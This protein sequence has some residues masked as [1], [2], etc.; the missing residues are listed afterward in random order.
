MAFTEIFKMVGRFKKIAV[1]MQK[2][3]TWISQNFAEERNNFWLFLPALIGF[4]AAFYFTFEEKFLAHFVVCVVL[5]SAAVIFYF[6]NRNSMRSLIFIACALFLLGSFYAHFYQKI[7][8][9]YTKISGKIYVEGVGKIVAV[10]KFIN[11]ANGVSGVNLVISEPKLYKAK[12]VEKKKKAKVKKKKKKV[13]KKTKS[14]NPK[15][16]KLKK[17]K[18]INPKTVEKNFVNLVGFQ[19]IDREFLDFSKN[20]QSVE[21]LRIKGKDTFPNPPPKI[22]LNIIKNSK[23]LKVN[24]VIAFRAMLQPL[25]AREFPEDFD[26]NLDA[27]FKKIGAYG[28]ILSE[29]KIVKDAEISRLDDWFLFLREKIRGKI[30]NVISGDEAAIASAFLI[31]D[32]SQISKATMDKIRNSGLAHLL[33]ISGFHLSLAGAICFIATRFILSRSEYLTLRFDL[34]K[35]AAI[36]AIF[37]TYFY[38]K[39]AASPLPAQRAFL[40]VILVLIALFVGE[41][42]NAKRAVMTAALTLIL[43]NPY[44]VFNISFQL[45]FAAILILVSFSSA[46]N[47]DENPYFLRRFFYYFAQIIL[48]SILIQIATAPFLM[49]S[50]QSLSILG[51]VTNVL[52]IPLTSFLVMPLG[53]AALILMPF[54]LEKYFLIL[55]KQGIF[56]IEEITI[57]VSDFNFSHFVSPAISSSGVILA[58]IG[59]LIFCLAQSHLRFVGIA[60]FSLSF[61]TIIFTEEPDILFEGRQKFFALNS[62]NQLIFSKNLKPSKQRES[63]MKRLQE[64][65]FR[66]LEDSPQ[67]DAFCDEKKCVIERGRK[68]LVLRGRNKLAEI[69]KNDFDVIVNLT[70]KYA[71]PDCIEKNKIRIDNFDFY[72]RGGHFIFFEK[73]KMR[74]ETS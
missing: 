25:K 3:T 69:C 53:F 39:I 16:K 40:M 6:F 38:L 68:F 17:K 67:Q 29:A 13:K 56:L 73:E 57:F 23:Q 12:F 66:S 2:I 28:F 60:I 18:K 43:A 37:G 41:K 58:T 47:Y 52:A 22:S 24:D 14:K 50:F 45:S 27:K 55:L 61:A 65:E 72:Q 35:I 32:Q 15:K 42:I 64:N 34:K 10:Q 20:Y 19:E 71:L 59:L 1:K 33:S 31:G 21:W 36:S 7:F 48:I 51:F 74:I 5:F 9:N 62:Q 30:L 44:A 46:K 26:F 49:R 70:S 4:G 54:G 63:W 8:V 11:P